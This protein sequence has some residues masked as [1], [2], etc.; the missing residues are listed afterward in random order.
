M[1]QYG[2]ITRGIRY[3]DLGEPAA[4]KM[5]QVLEEI[6]SGAFAEEWSGAQETSGEL[7]D[8]IKAARDQMP[9]AQWEA[10]AR[11][12]FGIGQPSGQDPS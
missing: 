8:K 4:E 7:L 1:E 5:R 2:S 11:K 10:D 6:R 9:I 3:L 12:A